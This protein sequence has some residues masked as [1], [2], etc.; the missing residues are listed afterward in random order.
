MDLRP[1]TVL[2]SFGTV[3]EAHTMPEAFK[4]SIRAAVRAFPDVTFIWKYEVSIHSSII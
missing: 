2:M 3:A 1:R 4:E